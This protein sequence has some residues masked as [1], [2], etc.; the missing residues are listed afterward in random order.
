MHWQRRYCGCLA[1]TPRN[2][3]V[4]AFDC[5]RW[6]GPVGRAAPTEQTELVLTEADQLPEKSADER[7]RPRRHPRRTRPGFAGRAAVRPVGDADARA[8]QGRIERHLRRRST[9]LLRRMPH[10]ALYEALAAT[11]PLAPLIRS[12]IVS[13]SIVRLDRAVRPLAAVVRRLRCRRRCGPGYAEFGILQSRA[14]SLRRPLRTRGPVTRSAIRWRSPMKV[15]DCQSVDRTSRKQNPIARHA[16]AS[17]QRAQQRGRGGGTWQ[18]GSLRGLQIGA[19]TRDGCR[20]RIA[21]V[22]QVEHEARIS[23]DISSKT[24]RS[25]S[26]SAQEFFYFS[27]QMHMPVPYSRMQLGG[28]L[29]PNAIP[30]CLGIFLSLIRRINDESTRVSSLS[31]CAPSAARIS[32]A[33]RGCS[34]ATRPTSS[35]S[36][37]AACPSG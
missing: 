11:A 7:A 17:D 30:T 14:Q 10:E 36:S 31:A 9:P 1:A 21:A 8:A 16:G 29:L 37:G 28:S 5:C 19:D 34:A 3:H 26:F 20:A 6:I 35:N 4:P 12:S 13:A 2:S 27:E 15:S 24:G 25:D 18:I 32:P 33:C 22:A 23:H